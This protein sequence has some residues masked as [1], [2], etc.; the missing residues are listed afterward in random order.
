MKPS[1]TLSTTT[2]RRSLNIRN[3][4]QLAATRREKQEWQLEKRQEKGQRPCKE[5]VRPQDTTWGTKLEA[6]QRDYNLTWQTTWMTDDSLE[7][8]SEQHWGYLKIAEARLD[9]LFLLSF[10]GPSLA[11]E[12]SGTRY[13]LYVQYSF[14]Q[15][16]SLQL[17]C[18][19][20]DTMTETASKKHRL[21][22][23]SFLFQV[24]GRFA[25]LERIAYPLSFFAAC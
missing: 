8:N 14:E 2:A 16:C 7:W 6:F 17:G 5:D 1:I 10:M 24:S 13:T 15:D 9:L 4:R 22:I 19:C 20:C 12:H 25:E 21:S 18:D 3:T 23:C 11:C